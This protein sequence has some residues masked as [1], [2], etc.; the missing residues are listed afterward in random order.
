MRLFTT[1]TCTNKKNVAYISW[2]ACFKKVEEHFASTTVP[3]FF[4]SCSKVAVVGGAVT[5]PPALPREDPKLAPGMLPLK[6]CLVALDVRRSFINSWRGRELGSLEFFFRLLQ[7]RR[8]DLVSSLKA[9]QIALSLYL[10][11]L[12]DTT[13]KSEFMFFR[14]PDRQVTRISQSS[15]GARLNLLRLTRKLAAVLY[16]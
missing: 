13:I 3:S 1:V 4:Q 7:D 15:F 5:T 6:D 8:A 14:C 16:L 11:D 2:F 12:P 10:L 9:K